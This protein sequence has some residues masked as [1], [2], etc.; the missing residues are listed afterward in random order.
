[1]TADGDGKSRWGALTAFLGAIAALITA[2]VGVVQLTGDDI[3]PPTG[4]TGGVGAGVVGPPRVETVAVKEG[5]YSGTAGDRPGLTFSVN[6]GE[7]SDIRATI[8]LQCRNR[9]TGQVG[10]FVQIFQ[11][12]PSTRGSID[13]KGGFSIDVHLQSQVFRMRG[14]FN[15][16]EANGTMSWVAA[17]D[18]TGNLAPS[19]AALVDCQTGEVRW[20]ASV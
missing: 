10:T 16:D 6:S 4:G 7:V 3:R 5:T 15:G 14:T 11:S 20:S 18:A 1:V 17:L 12:F 19:D 8:G 13:D 2:I 9:Q